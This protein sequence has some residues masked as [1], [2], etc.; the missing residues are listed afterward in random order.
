M[1]AR[2]PLRRARRRQRE[3]WP[4]YLLQASAL[5]E[6]NRWPEAKQALETRRWRS[7]PTSRCCSISSA[8]PSSSAAR[9]SIA[10]EAM[11][12]KAS[13]LAPDDASITDS[14]G[15][16]QFKRGQG[17]RSDRDAPASR[18]R[19]PRPGRDPRASRRRL[20]TSGRRFEARFAWRAALVTAEDDVAARLEGQ[21]R[22]RADAGQRRALSDRSARSAPAKLNLA[23]HVRGKLPD[24]RHAI[25]TIFA[26]CTDGDRLSAEPAD[27]L[28][29]DVSGPFAAELAAGEDNLV[30]A[31]RAGRL[32]EAA[33]CCDGRC[34]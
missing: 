31:R 9:T 26:F 32:R 12:R 23:L 24:G 5:E 16:A 27:E 11:I 19:G 2:S 1:A 20:Y 25:E 28:S 18:A 4:L 10:A 15:W 3:L 6:A 29:L 7:R 22:R 14:L 17:R 30:D 13:E 8:M 21:D 33:G 34:D